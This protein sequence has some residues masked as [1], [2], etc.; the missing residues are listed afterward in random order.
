MKIVCSFLTDRPKNRFSFLR[1]EA[2]A[3]AVGLVWVAPIARADNSGA[4][5]DASANAAGVGSNPGTSNSADDLTDLSLEQLHDLSISAA[6]KHSE[7]LFETP[8]AVS[9]LLPVDLERAGASSIAESL[10]LVPGLHVIDQLPMDWDVGVRGGNGIQSTKLL[11][12][13]DGRSVYDPFFGGVIWSTAEIA[14][15]D[16]ARV[17]VVRGPGA[18]L[19]GANA[20]NGVINVISKDAR[21]TQGSVLSVRSGSEEPTQAHV[22]YGAQLDSNTW[23]R[24]Y[25]GGANTEGATGQIADDPNSGYREY[26]TGYRSDTVL[27]PS[28]T[29]TSQFDYLHSSRVLDGETSTLEYASF[30]TRLQLANFAGGEL[31]LQVYFDSSRQNSGDSDLGGAG[32]LTAA[33][34]E[35]NR[36][37]DFDLTHHFRIGR[38]DITWGGGA[39]LTDNKV[40]NTK[41]LTMDHPRLESWLVNFFVQDEV[42]LTSTLKLTVG[43]KMEHRGTIGWDPLPN[44]RLAWIPNSR[45]MFWAAAS[46]ALRA[47]SR[48]EREASILLADS[49]ATDTSLPVR[50]E[51]KGNEGFDD[52]ASDAYEFGWRWWPNHHFQ[53]DFSGYD[54]AYR[55]IRNL[56]STTFIEPG[57]PNTVVISESLDNSA[58]AQTRGAEVS[59]KYRP[60]DS[61]ELNGGIAREAAFTRNLTENPLVA[62]DYWVP[63]WLW[64]VGSWWQLPNEWEFSS[65]LYGVGK[66]PRANLPG[67]LRLDVQLLWRPRPDLE[68]IF[69][70]QNLNDPDHSEVITGNILPNVEVRR[71]FYTRV[72]WRF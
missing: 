19:W 8:A 53:F 30:L 69:G 26:R 16:L 66:N 43:S 12:L 21:D 13:V 24:V 20:V 32:S 55:H 10:R 17:E 40:E 38:N 65:T 52:E 72:Q 47:P 33:V 58:S 5:G 64:H 6:S 56:E 59:W 14:L 62:A 22:R 42:P 61:W 46:R 18:T 2:V 39:R 9:V 28:A 48:G 45:E 37:L 54:F 41:N 70:V 49:P 50:V 15:D 25:A 34:N 60:T 71:D 7:P 57:L 23:I 67:Y 31:Q 51:L 27:S 35:T 4:I 3:L 36:D 1:P 63:D 68:V 44:V 11:V 29:F